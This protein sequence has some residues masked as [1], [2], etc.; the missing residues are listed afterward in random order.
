VC[1]Q[2]PV[3]GGCLVMSDR[4]CGVDSWPSIACAGCGLICV[5]A[6][7]EQ[8]RKVY[9]CVASRCGETSRLGS[10]DPVADGITCGP[11][12]GKSKTKSCTVPWLS[13]KAKNKPR[14][15]WRPSH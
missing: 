15:P 1:V 4:Q 10:R 11:H 12:G 2:G 6:N 8:A 9:T 14:R 5:G 3:D 7:E 13:L